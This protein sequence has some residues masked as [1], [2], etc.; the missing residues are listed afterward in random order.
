MLR[1]TGTKRRLVVATPI[2]QIQTRTYTLKMKVS[3]NTYNVPAAAQEASVL[4]RM[5]G[6]TKTTAFRALNRRFFALEN[7]LGGSIARNPLAM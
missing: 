4:L 7:S 2:A 3:A 6:P 1:S 5:M